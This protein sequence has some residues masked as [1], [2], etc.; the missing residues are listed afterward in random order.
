[1]IAEP[2]LI[3]HPVLVDIRVETRFQAIDAIRFEFNGDVA[4]DATP[5]ANAV[6]FFHEPWAGFEE[7]ILANQCTD[8]TDIN[9]IASHFVIK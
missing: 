8:W 1:M 4:P 7:K 3:A 2:P 6:D 9:D 5:R